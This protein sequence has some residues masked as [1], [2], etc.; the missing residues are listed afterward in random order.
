MSGE[1]RRTKERVDE[2]DH[3]TLTVGDVEDAYD[4]QRVTRSVGALAEFN[5]AGVLGPADVHVAEALG[6]LGVE[7]SPDVLLA[8]A[9]AV[10]SA[11][12]GSVCLDLST[13]RET[14]VVEGV[15]VDSLPWPTP[16]G[17][18]DALGASPLVAVGADAQAGK[19]L[20]LVGSVVYLDRYWRDEQIVAAAVDAAHVRPAPEVDRER[21]R[22]AVDRL[23]GSGDADR[24]RLA[25]IVAAGRWFSVIAGGPGT[26]K[27]TTVARLL[28]LLCDQPGPAPRLA[29]AAPTGRAAARLLEAVTTQ[30]AQFDSADRDRLGDLRA[31][32]LHRL[33]GWKPGSR[34]RFRHDRTNPLPYDAVIVDEASMVSLTMMARLADALRTD[35]RLVLVGDPDQLASVEVG[36]VLGDLVRREA[37]PGSV[38]TDTHL[39]EAD[40]AD[41]DAAERRAALTSG[42][43]RLAHVYRFSGQIEALA[44][45]VRRGDADTVL[46]L[47]DDGSESVELVESEAGEGLRTDVVGAGAAVVEAARAGDAARAVDALG[48]HRL[49]CA[50]REGRTALPGGACGPRIGCASGWTGT[51]ATGP[52]TSAGRCSS[53]RTTTGSGCSTV[54]Q[55]S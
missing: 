35:A 36:A 7:E 40:L 23:F 22:A 16:Q 1:E 38:E 48:V 13:A 46:G 43:V 54:T 50:H 24:Q 53:P 25:A 10:R 52:G 20:R 45:G 29:L 33:L 55:E 17:W 34:T 51:P 14:T 6:R 15:A 2:R 8:I 19:P 42:V 18:V 41:L 21:L 28:A 47:L 39:V 3:L 11:R 49:L 26:G 5:R 37:A 27:T 44:E 12:L 30:A 4:V 32:T 31:S 9:L